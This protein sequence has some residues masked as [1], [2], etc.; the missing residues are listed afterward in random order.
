METSNIRRSVSY[1]DHFCVY[2]LPYCMAF[3][4][5]SIT[6]V[7]VYTIRTFLQ[8][9]PPNTKNASTEVYEHNKERL[10]ATLNKSYDQINEFPF[11][12][13]CFCSHWQ[14]VI[15]IYILE[16]HLISSITDF[17]QFGL[18]V[19]NSPGI[20]GGALIWDLM[21]FLNFVY[22]YSVY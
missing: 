22:A 5:I 8:G 11:R 2:Y 12:S 13:I 9:C 18:L 1:I 15:N 21:C 10:T 6:F 3:T 7:H 14:H 20:A 17:V 4:Q 19:N 16:K